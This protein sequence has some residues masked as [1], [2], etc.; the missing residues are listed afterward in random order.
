MYREKESLGTS[1]RCKVQVAPMNCSRDGGRE[2]LA[3]QAGVRLYI[4]IRAWIT[5]SRRWFALTPDVVGSLLPWL[6]KAAGLGDATS[7]L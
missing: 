6:C 7:N 2:G 3:V 1:P 4:L 5:M